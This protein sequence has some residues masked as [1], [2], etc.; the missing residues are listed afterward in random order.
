MKKILSCIAIALIVALSFS[1]LVS[2]IDFP[3]GTT[4]NISQDNILSG[5]SDMLYGLSLDDSNMAI[6]GGLVSDLINDG[7]F[8]FDRKYSPWGINADKYEVLNEDGLNSWNSKYCSL[9]VK[10]KATVENRG[11]A[12]AYANRSGYSISRSHTGEIGYK[13]NEKYTFS[14]YFK[15]IDF[16]GKVTL[17]LNAKG[18]TEEHNIDI[19][20]CQEWTKITVEAVSQVTAD[21]SLLLVFEGEGT[22][23]LD[24]VSLVPQSS[25]GYNDAGWKYTTLRADIVD[26]IKKLSPS[27][28]RFSENGFVDE[29]GDLCGWKNTIGPLETRKFVS[30]KSE[31][32]YEYPVGM[33]FY[34][35]LKLCEDLNAFAIPHFNIGINQEEALKYDGYYAQYTDG[36]ISEAVWQEY[37]SGL[38]LNVESEE[39]KIIVQDILDVLEYAMGDETTIWGAQRIADGHNEPFD[40]QYIALGKEAVGEVYWTNFTAV[41]KAV[42]EKYPH[43][44]I[45][46]VL[47]NNF[48]NRASNTETLDIILN[49]QFDTKKT[50]Y[51]NIVNKYDDYER[52]MSNIAIEK[53]AFSENN[54]M[55]TAIKN[56][57]LFTE[58]E[59]NSDIVKMS[60]YEWTLAKRDA[61]KDKNAL[62]WYDA[63]KLLLTTD[64]YA[65]MLFANNTGSKQ[66]KTDFDME[67]DGVYQSVTID[68]QNQVIYVKIVNTTKVE[69]NL[70]LS[71]DGFSNVKTST[72]QYM[73]E[74]FK[75]AYNGFD[76]HLHVAPV[77]KGLTFEENNIP[78]HIGKYSINVIRIPYGENDGKALFQLPKTDIISPY[79]HPA[80]SVVIPTALGVLILIT[81]MV[82]LL[83]RMRHHTNANKK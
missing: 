68:E 59:K 22:V 19:S 27:F 43:I 69:H 80:I 46:S 21:G 79:I 24:F 30:V 17:Y 48:S 66:I 4:F 2:A 34:E 13:Q 72:M 23:Y 39:F 1:F 74:N 49:E 41:Y 8:E 77:L 44:K 15:N 10:S 7:S 67:D 76:E 60:S 55:E 81:G 14:A 78:V 53:F 50:D 73:S 65:Q 36:E 37:V 3:K 54:D 25:Y 29:N 42:K 58:L 62:V 71:L 31:K 38:A 64:Y 51:A 11:Y 45:I 63:Q 16:N 33:G 47:D 32:E 40:I 28:I 70:T 82:I 18:N 12:E 9:T 75:S 83:E 35:Y 56:A 5:E 61:H 57:V 26:A 20:Q 6:A 52:A